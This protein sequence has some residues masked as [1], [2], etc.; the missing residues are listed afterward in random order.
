[1]G[2][3]FFLVPELGEV[4]LFDCLFDFYSDNPSRLP[5]SG[6]NEL[7]GAFSDGRRQRNRIDLSGEGD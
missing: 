4:T 2:F 3:F 1:M 5:A 6:I 7:A